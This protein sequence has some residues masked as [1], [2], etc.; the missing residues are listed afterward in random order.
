MRHR[1]GRANHVTHVRFTV[2]IQRSRHTKE[3]RIGFCEPRKVGGGSAA[4]G[5]RQTLHHF[6]PKMFDVRGAGLDVGNF[7]LVD[8]IPYDRHT[9]FVEGVHER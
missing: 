3:H 7:G 2:L 1:F 6:L 5:L 4:I 8:V 9:F